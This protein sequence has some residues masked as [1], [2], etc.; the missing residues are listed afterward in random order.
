MVML[1]RRTGVMKW[2]SMT[3]RRVM[4]HSVI[5]TALRLLV[6]SLYERY[7]VYGYIND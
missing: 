1:T 2:M 3:L 5:S 4:M 6:G 7:T